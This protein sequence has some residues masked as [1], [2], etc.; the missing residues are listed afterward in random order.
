MATILC[1]AL[2]QRK[3]FFSFGLDRYVTTGG[4]FHY[5]PLCPRAFAPGSSFHFGNSTQRTL[6]PWNFALIAD[7]LMSPDEHVP[8]ALIGTFTTYPWTRWSPERKLC[9]EYGLC[10]GPRNVLFSWRILKFQSCASFV[11]FESR[12]FYIVS[13]CKSLS[14]VSTNRKANS[15]KIEQIFWE[16]WFLRQIWE[17]VWTKFI[18]NHEWNVV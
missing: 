17:C 11:I 8:Q 16:I 12:K 10:M 3:Y 2:K 1:Q 14:R 4:P 18:G 9:A 7:K 13:L 15:L 6:L 5:V